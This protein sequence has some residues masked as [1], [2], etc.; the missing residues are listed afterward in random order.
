MSLKD[1]V[2]IDVGYPVYGAKFV[3]NKTLVVAGGG[4]EGNNGIPNK[5]TAIK[6]SFKIKDK[7]RRLQRFREITLPTNEDSPTCIEINKI[8]NTFTEEKSYSVFVGCNQSNELIKSMNANNNLRKYVFTDD[9]HLKFIDA[10]QLDQEVTNEDIGVYPKI[11]NLSPDNSMGLLMTSKEPSVVYLFDPEALECLYRFESGVEIRDFHLCAFDNG[12]SLAFVTSTSIELVSVSSNSVS[13][14]ESSN[15]HAAVKKTLGA[16]ILTK[17]RYIGEDELLIS[18]NVRKG[19]V[20]LL[21]YSIK[22]KSIIKIN[23]FSKKSKGLVAVDVSLEQNLVAVAAN[24]FSMTLLRL[25]D[26]K[27]LKTFPKLHTFAITSVCFSPNGSK[28]AAV[29]ASNAVRVFKIPKKFAHGKSVIGTLINYVFYTLLFGLLAIFLQISIE[30]GKLEEAFL[31]SKEFT[32]SQFE[33]LSGLSI[34]AYELVKEKIKNEKLDGDDNTKKYFTINEWEDSSVSSLIAAETPM[35]EPVDTANDI[36]VEISRSEDVS[37]VTE[38]TEFTE[39][40]V[41]TTIATTLEPHFNIEPK[42]EYTQ[43]TTIPDN[44][45]FVDREV[46]DDEDLTSSVVEDTLTSSSNPEDIDA[47]Y[48]ADVEEPASGSEP[49]DLS[50]VEEVTEEEVTEEEPEA[51]AVE[52]PEVDTVETVPEAEEEAEVEEVLSESVTEDYVTAEEA[53]SSEVEE[54]VEIETETESEAETE[55]ETEGYVNAEEADSSE[56]EEVVEIE[57]ET[58]SEAETESETEGYVTAEEADSSEVEEVVEIETETESEAE[59][60][61][62]TEGYVT[63]EEADSSEV[64]EVVEI[65]TETESEAETESET[66]GYFTAEEADTEIED[67]T[68]EATENEEV[69]GSGEANEVKTT[70][71]DSTPVVEE[72]DESEI[73]ETEETSETEEVSAT[74]EVSETEELSESESDAIESETETSETEEVNGVSETKSEVSE[75][76]PETKVTKETPA[77]TGISKESSTTP[78]PTTK[79]PKKK[80]KKRTVT[81]KVKKP[82]TKTT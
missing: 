76:T 41:E 19:G 21:K 74:E 48:Q 61:S 59:T 60:E 30:N 4:G 49:S 28:L 32:I 15:K 69:P 39:S 40:V 7:N 20:A 71:V 6:C 62:E 14:V 77:S 57:T 34:H 47:G 53:D 17:V 35:G 23:N 13:V 11:I 37:Q 44:A 80:K 8:E 27:V 68:E 64:E 16:Y 9:E 25:S 2:T 45:G 38:D 18:A 81:R 50:E 70:E 54:V 26:L 75:S 3:N 36:V 12:Q 1:S 65:E 51:E 56:V 73:V 29:S 67:T 5:I 24:D 22:S 10:A 66:E 63:A 33:Y 78:K 72:V 43:N 58:E 31:V 46:S 82:K 79:K 52:E 42:V 55:S